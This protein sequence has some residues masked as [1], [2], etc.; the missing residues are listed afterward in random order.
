MPKIQPPPASLPM[1]RPST[2]PG[3]GPPLR[4]STWSRP[5]EPLLLPP[6]TWPLTLPTETMGPFLASSLPPPGPSHRRPAWPVATLSLSFSAFLR[7]G[8]HA[9]ARGSRSK[10]RSGPSQPE[11]L[12]GTHISPGDRPRE[13]SVPSI[14][15]HCQPQDLCPCCSFCPRCSSTSHVSPVTPQRPPPNPPHLRRSPSA[16]GT[17]PLHS[18]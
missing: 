16:S 12:G 1:G 10:V 3:A 11:A 15:G 14:L 4:R 8:P 17:L 18:L 2:S 7:A 5:W 9:G 13:P 6:H